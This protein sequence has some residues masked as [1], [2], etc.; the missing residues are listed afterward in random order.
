MG[1]ANNLGDDMPGAGA[2]KAQPSSN[3]TNVVPLNHTALQRKLQG[4][5]V[6][7]LYNLFRVESQL[8]VHNFQRILTSFQKKKE[9]EKYD[10]VTFVMAP[11]EKIG[12]SI[13][14]QAEKNMDQSEQKQIKRISLNKNRSSGS[15]GTS[16]N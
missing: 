2:V 13:V 10:F 12:S 11:N 1:G 9:E 3:V 7:A 16:V 8:T 4:R 15:A 5:V 14:D 6:A